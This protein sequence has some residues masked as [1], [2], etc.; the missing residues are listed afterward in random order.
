LI[1]VPLTSSN[2]IDK[3]TIWQTDVQAVAA[4]W[5]SRAGWSVTG[6][7]ATGDQVLIQATWPNPAPGLAALR[8]DLD[9]AGLNG[10]EVRVSLTPASYKPL[11]G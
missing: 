1:I 3:T 8:H 6:V 2:R 10:L 7:T 11:P 9:A 4:H 5:A